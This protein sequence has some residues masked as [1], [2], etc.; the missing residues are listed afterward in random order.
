MYQDEF[1]AICDAA[2][3]MEVREVAP[4]GKTPDIPGGA[5]RSRTEPRTFDQMR[6]AKPLGRNTEGVAAQ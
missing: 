4:V 2:R 1:F 5:S 6:S 3:T